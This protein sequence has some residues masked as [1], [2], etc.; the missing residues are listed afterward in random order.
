MP[1]TDPGGLV[2]CGLEHFGDVRLGSVEFTF[3]VFV[4][5]GVAIQSGK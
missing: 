2:A 5:I 4:A 1:F 3:V